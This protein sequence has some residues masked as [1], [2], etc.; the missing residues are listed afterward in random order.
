MF[1]TLDDVMAGNTCSDLEEP[2]NHEYVNLVEIVREIDS[3]GGYDNDFV[4]QP[5]DDLLCKIC[6]YPPRTPILTVCC[7]HNFCT[8][9]LQRYRLSK[10]IDHASCPY[11][12]TPQFQTMPDKRTERY[13]L[14][15]KVFCLH[16]DRG[17]NW[18][19]ELRSVDKHVSE[20][21]SINVGCPYTELPCSNG[22]GVVMQRRLMEGHLKSECELREVNC[23]YCS[24]T[25]IFRW[26]FGSHQ[27]ECL[28][29]PVECPNHCEVGHVRREEMGEHL[30]E[31][32]LA[33]VECP[34]AVVGCESVVRRKEQMKHVMRS[35]GEHMEYNKNAILYMKNELESVKEDSQNTK[36]KLDAKERELQSVKKDLE[37]T[38]NR[39]D[40]R[41]QE[42]EDIKKD[43]RSTWERSN[44]M[45]QA[46][47]NIKRDLQ[48]RLKASQD[49][50]AH[51]KMVIT[52]KDREM[53]EMRKNTA[54]NIHTLNEMLQKLQNRVE[55]TEKSLRHQLNVTAP[56]FESV[57]G[58]KWCMELNS[59]ASS[60]NHTLPVVFKLT[61]FE[62]YKKNSGI[63]DSPAFYTEGGGYQ[64]YL[65]VFPNGFNT[66]GAHGSHVSVW[67]P[68]MK[69]DHDDHL[70]WPVKGT[71]MVQ[72]LNQISD[73]NHSDPVP[74]YFD[75]TSAHCQRVTTSRAVSRSGLWAFQF[76][77]HKKLPYDSDRK[78]QYLKDDC[79]FFKVCDFQ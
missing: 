17:C 74:F 31:C 33:I 63:W 75:G 50:Q 8:T 45:E 64:M 22:C 11:C 59:L 77:P 76:I 24:T 21:S 68:L 46:I 23:N 62:K 12:R 66:V 51:L 53:A 26:I 4:E 20:K 54:E 7:G 19:G 57:F 65:K 1:T 47:I 32:P 49:I 13:V 71:L 10:V 48:E 61:D 30:E 16:K 44:F 35:V 6:Q 9:C 36:D 69:G 42:L 25:G 2:D 43:L 41:E 14:N 58:S 38:K 79:V 15:L 55:D 5:A 70:S 27:E 3:M 40:A 28:N 78:C 37:V 39:L 29:Y 67:V 56:L 73:D 34:Y 60:S 72:L 52:E 18:I